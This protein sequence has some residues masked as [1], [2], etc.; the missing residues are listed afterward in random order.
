MHGLVTGLQTGLET[1]LEPS[2][3]FPLSIVSLPLSLS[4]SPPL[5]FKFLNGLDGSAGLS[6]FGEAQAKPSRAQTVKAIS[7]RLSQTV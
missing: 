7:S 6:R 3:S 5:S 2:L 4:L 1:G